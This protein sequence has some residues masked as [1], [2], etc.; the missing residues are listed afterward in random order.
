M[1]DRIQNFMEKQHMLQNGD[2]VLV[3]VSGGADSVCLLRVLKAMSERMELEI[4]ALH[5]EH[6]IRGEASLQDMRFVKELCKKLSVDCECQG[7]DIPKMAKEEGC[8][9]EEMGRIMRYKTFDE[10]ANRIHADKIAVAHHGDDLVETMLF[11]LCRG[12]GVAG[13]TPI[14]PVRGKI[15][16]PLLCVTREEIEG[17]LEEIKQPYC[18]DATNFDTDYTRNKIRHQVIPVLKQVNSQSVQHFFNTANSVFMA[19]QVLEK[20]KSRVWQEYVREEKGLMIKESLMKELPYLVMEVIRQAMSE[21]A[22][23]RKD[24]SMVHVEAMEQLFSSQAGKKIDLPYG[25]EAHRDYQGITLKKKGTRS[26]EEKVLMDKLVIPG[27]TILKDG[28]KVVT[29]I[30]RHEDIKSEIPRKKYTKWMDYDII[31]D[32]LYFRQMRPDDYMVIDTHGNKKKI[33]K[34][35]VDERVPKEKRQEEIILASKNRV[36]WVA[37]VRMSEDVKVTA[38]TKKIIEIRIYEGE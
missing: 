3:G 34:L 2:H 17:Y 36:F 10:V 19:Q 16:R 33:K 14:W 8:S 29:R 7:F 32:D 11:F 31:N 38:S 4:T 21:V 12:T 18:V 30:I 37:G 23:S 22:G 28:R 26:Q 9:E 15:I 25:M 6:G 27:E 1:I 20:E 5:V 24:I 35:F 13:L